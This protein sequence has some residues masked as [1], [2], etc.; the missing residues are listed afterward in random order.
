MLYAQIT[1]RSH[2]LL[3][4]SLRGKIHKPFSLTYSSTA[5]GTD[6]VTT[7]HNKRSVKKMVPYV[8]FPLLYFVLW[9]TI[10]N[11]CG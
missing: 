8:A 10:N 3:S 2:L 1:F 9:K 6:G 4:E 5:K 7:V 11:S